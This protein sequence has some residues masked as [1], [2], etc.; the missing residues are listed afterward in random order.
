MSVGQLGSPRALSSQMFVD[1]E[2]FYTTT[3]P[4]DSAP[5]SPPNSCNKRRVFFAIAPTSSR[6]TQ[7]QL[8]LSSTAGMAAL[9][10]FG[11]DQILGRG[12]MKSVER[13]ENASFS[14][15]VSDFDFSAR[16]SEA[17]GVP[18][19][20]TV[21]SSADELFYNGQIRPLQPLHESCRFVAENAPSQSDDGYTFDF[22]KSANYNVSAFHSPGSPKV[23]QSNLRLPINKHRDQQTYNPGAWGQG[24]CLRDERQIA[25]W[26]QWTE[27]SKQRKHLF[28]TSE[29]TTLR[30]GDCAKRIPRS[31]DDLIWQTSRKRDVGKRFPKSVDDM[32]ERGRQSRQQR[33]VANGERGSRDRSRRI[34]RSLSPLRVFHWEDQP[35]QS[36]ESDDIFSTTSSLDGKDQLRDHQ[37]SS[38]RKSTTRTLKEFL[39][40]SDGR[41]HH[42]QSW[43]NCTE[44]SYWEKSLKSCELGTGRKAE[45]TKL[46]RAT[47]QTIAP[48]RSKTFLRSPRGAVSPHELHYAHQRAHSEQ[49]RKKTFLPYRQGVLGCLGFS[50]STR[51][52]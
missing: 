40:M 10:P 34:S 7:L 18:L 1:G 15:T 52:H 9:V 49:M 23:H 5:S 11:R 33:F 50:H 17:D 28:T 22:R 39:R 31:A 42:R 41:V 8:K 48:Q 47:L 24:N 14:M 46:L 35:R 2:N 4:S 19:S 13:E 36:C 16:F 43:R 6:L 37:Q 26:D 51:S 21:M 29:Q 3:I 20:P 30:Q 27:N 38:P 25:A 44:A 45:D 12:D 32:T